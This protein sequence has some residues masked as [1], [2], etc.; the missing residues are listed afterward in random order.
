MSTALGLANIALG[1]YTLS[2]AA[3][4]RRRPRSVDGLGA[5]PGEGQVRKRTLTVRNIDE[6]VSR[7]GRMIKLGRED[8]EIRKFAVQAVSRRCGDGWCTPEK[9]NA[10]EVKAIFNAV[11]QNVR[12]SGDMT[13]ADTFQHPRRTLEFGGGDCD[14]FTSLTGAALEAIGIPVRMRV[15]Q[16]N[17]SP[18]YNHIYIIA[19]LPPQGP[20][21]WVPLDASVNKPAGWEVPKSMI[22]RKRDFEVG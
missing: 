13:S 4:R 9:D 6:R 10:A 18:D 17:D 3:R 16:T 20:R 8:P 14:D 21:K 12:Y 5:R 11:R 7:V 22:R 1:I 19:G 2:R 15:I